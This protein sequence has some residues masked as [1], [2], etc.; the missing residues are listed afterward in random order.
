MPKLDL[1]AVPVRSGCSYPQQ[2]HR[3]AGDLTGN[4][5][6]ALGDAAG[7]TQF[8]VNRCVYPPGAAS[9]LR[10]W[11]TEED[12]FVIVLEGE[13]VLVTDDGETPLRAGDM[14]GFPKGAPNG[15]HLRNKS[16]RPAVVL[17]IGTRSE[18]DEC[19]YS[20]VDMRARSPAQG[21]GYVTRAGAPYPKDQ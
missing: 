14:A 2:F 6:Q 10:H 3:I 4:S 16:L 18:N 5:W 7:L 13:L 19:F 11:H 1:A 12:E 15:H 21:G 9:S 17:E 8:G 20:D